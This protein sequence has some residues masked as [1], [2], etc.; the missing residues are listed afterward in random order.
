MAGA[1]DQRLQRGALPW[2]KLTQA[3]YL[4]RARRLPSARQITSRWRSSK[5]F[6]FLNSSLDNT[7]RARENDE[8][9][10]QETASYKR[11]QF[12]N[13]FKRMRIP[14]REGNWQRKGEAGSLR[15]AAK[16]S[17]AVVA[18]LAQCFLNRRP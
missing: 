2:G 14:C 12:R 15:K 18:L 17:F 5:A 4:C 7:W 3:F 16:P 8:Q 10:H 9:Q 1:K 6:D 11:S 13:G